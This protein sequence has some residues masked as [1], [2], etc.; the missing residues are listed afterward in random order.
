MQSSTGVAASVCR[1]AVCALVAA[2]LADSASA[3]QLMPPTAAGWSS[4]SARPATAPAVVTS[5]GSPY[6]L[7]IFGNGVPNVYGGW[8]ARLQPL[9]GG[10]PY[11][12]HARVTATGIA[13]P[14][15]SITVLLRW[16]GSF[17]DEVAPDYVW[18]YGTAADG[19]LV[20]DRTLAAPP[21]TTA[22]DVE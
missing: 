17:G 22:V 4:F 5:A 14:R 19:S 13:S 18:E 7:E 11:R 20:F 9:S 3:Q 6:S 8:R 10:Q 15:D 16:R 12:F 21:G 1:L 2:S